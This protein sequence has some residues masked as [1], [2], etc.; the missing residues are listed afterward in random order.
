MV[1][2]ASIPPADVPMT[3]ASY[4]LGCMAYPRFFVNSFSAAFTPYVYKQLKIGEDE[5]EKD[6]GIKKKI[7]KTC[8]LAT[9]IFGVLL[10][11]SYVLLALFI[12]VCFDSS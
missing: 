11:V 12:R 10:V 6:L 5:K 4:G 3:M 8:Y 1:F 7:V 9:V 2:K